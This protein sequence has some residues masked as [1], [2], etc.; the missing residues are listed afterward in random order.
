MTSR[1]TNLLDRDDITVTDGPRRLPVIDLDAAVPH[2]KPV[3]RR[4]DADIMRA[5]RVLG[6]SSSSSWRNI[7][8]AYLELVCALGSSCLADKTRY[9]AEL[10]RAY[11][12]LCRLHH[13]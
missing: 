4:L 7:Q 12:I 13:R 11:A 1:M 5:S 8:R 2:T 9:E 3:R 6:V 10:N